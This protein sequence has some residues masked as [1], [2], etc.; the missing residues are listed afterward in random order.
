MQEI[1]GVDTPVGK[2]DFPG[3]R[4]LMDRLM[5][6][7]CGKLTF[8]ELPCRRCGKLAFK[9]VL[10]KISQQ[11]RRSRLKRW[12]A[13]P[14]FLMGMLVLAWFVW[15]PLVLVA[16]VPVYATLIQ[17]SFQKTETERTLEHVYWLLHTEGKAERGNLSLADATAVDQLT[18]AYDEDLRRLER[19][20]ENNNTTEVA[21]RVFRMAQ[22]LSEVFHNRRV[23]AL[24]MECLMRL[25]VGLGFN[26]DVDQVCAFLEPADLKN[27]E[28][29]LL[30]LVDCVKL[31]SI[32]S[33]FAT[34][35]F[36]VK[37]CAA[38][39]Q[40]RVLSTVDPYTSIIDASKVGELWSFFP[41]PEK[42]LLRDLWAY[43]AIGLKLPLN[44][45]QSTSVSLNSMCIS[46]IPKG[47]NYLADY[48]FQ[49]AWY[50]GKSRQRREL[51][52]FFYYYIQ[53]E[54][55]HTA[56]R[57]WN[58]AAPVMPQEHRLTNKLLPVKSSRGMT[59]QYL[60][61]KLVDA[62]GSEIGQGD[63]YVAFSP[64]M[65]ST[66]RAEVLAHCNQISPAMPDTK[67]VFRKAYLS[68][69]RRVL[70]QSL[71]RWDTQYPKPFHVAHGYLLP[72]RSE[73]AL[74]PGNWLSV[75][76]NL[77]DL[78]KSQS[79]IRLDSLETLDRKKPFVP[80]PLQETIEAIGGDGETF[81][82]LLAGCFGAPAYGVQFILAY[83]AKTKGNEL[84]W[85][86][87][88]YWI[89]SCLP[90]ELRLRLGV[91]SVY[92]ELSL[93]DKIHI[94]FLDVE[95]IPEHE[96]LKPDTPAEEVRIPKRKETVPLGNNMLAIN[97]YVINGKG[98]TD[99]ES[100]FV[101]WLKMVAYTLWESNGKLLPELDKIYQKFEEKLELVPYEKR[102]KPDTY[103]AVCWE[104]LKQ[105]SNAFAEADRQIRLDTSRT[106]AYELEGIAKQ[107]WRT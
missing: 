60:Y 90:Y 104:R 25:P 92:T 54:P 21:A 4:A 91:D 83:D 34:A 63:G 70:L 68:E 1:W 98:I 46:D 58:H 79:D 51:R 106:K 88:L 15:K 6:C 94:A 96:K 95:G 97:G 100:V 59:E 2:D 36:T 39:V 29:A 35:R 55:I 81:A 69:C 5:V 56:M 18:E 22:S 66:M 10:S 19:I 49:R 72:T 9:P 78:N 11:E 102:L 87:I 73:D 45:E 43:S 28:A 67:P 48:W 103:D 65:D 61:Q 24:M 14:V 23:S 7:P 33:G 30:K 32:P 64:G 62:K 93:P 8:L 41:E 44:R 47:A 40:E 74:Q 42:Q 38:R 77:T 71:V 84:R 13:A 27:K 37:M 75:K 105:Y 99:N 101:K 26:I 86:D 89:F 57:N 31:S 53:K 3:S 16:A 80:K 107:Y 20:V 17:E 76:Y 82:M 12:L 50:K 85:M 52:K